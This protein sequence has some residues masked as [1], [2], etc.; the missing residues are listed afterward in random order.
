MKRL[1]GIAYL[2]LASTLGIGSASAQMQSREVHATVP[3]DFTVANKQFP[4]GTYSIARAK[5]GAIEILDR[6]GQV[7]MITLGFEA[8]SA[9]KGCDLNFDR[10]GGQY[11]M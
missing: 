5:N 7:V 11:F 8:G 1:T 3:F 2:A 6:Q 10:R 4:A 9:S